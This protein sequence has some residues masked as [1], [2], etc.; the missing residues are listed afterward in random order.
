M[1]VQKSRRTPSTRGMRRSHDALTTSALSVE[2]PRVKLTCVITLVPMV[3]I[4]VA[5]SSTQNKTTR[6]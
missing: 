3:T 5:R 6:S 1:A 4:V 2:P